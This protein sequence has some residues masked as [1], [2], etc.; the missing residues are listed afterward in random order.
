[1]I[2]SCEPYSCMQTQTSP[3]L[4]LLLSGSTIQMLQIQAV[5]FIRWA[6]FL[7]NVAVWTF[8]LFFMVQIKK[9]K[10]KDREG[11]WFDWIRFTYVLASL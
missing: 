1:M 3:T 9:K 6:I 4:E 11:V 10:K 7:V 2:A 5:L 8:D